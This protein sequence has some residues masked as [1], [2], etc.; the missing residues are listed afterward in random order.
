M[1]PWTVPCQD[2][3]SMGFPRQEYC[4]GLPF[5]SL[6]DV[7]NQGIELTS[8]A[9]VGG[10]FTTEPAGKPCIILTALINLQRLKNTSEVY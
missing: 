8:S 6:G 7:P 3:L 9:L 10:F 1:T 5:L 4:S 2:P